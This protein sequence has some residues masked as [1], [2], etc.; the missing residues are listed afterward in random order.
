M[1]SL[2]AGLVDPASAAL[3]DPG[4]GAQSGAAESP[5][6][7]AIR[8]SLARRLPE[9]MVPSAFVLLDELP[10]TAN[11]KV[12]RRALPPADAIAET[13][14]TPHVEPRT[15][16][17]RQLVELVEGLLEVEGVGVRDNFAD[18][19]AHSVHMVQLQRRVREAFGRE[20]AITSLFRNPTIEGLAMELGPGG[21]APDP[22]AGSR[23][24]AASRKAALERRRGPG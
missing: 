12:D 18:L 4:E 8:E 7:F 16:L 9:Y 5:L 6:V 11:G 3:D 17:E 21:P 2:A 1:Y 14:E 15:D 10:L 20:V 24:R 23:D 13:R 19:G 22:L